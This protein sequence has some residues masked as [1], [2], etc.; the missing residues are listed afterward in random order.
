[1]V[2]IKLESEGYLIENKILFGA[3]VPHKDYINFAIEIG[4]D[5]V[6]E[7]LA[8]SIIEYPGEYDIDGIFIKSF[9]SKDGKLNYV[10]TINNKTIGLIQSPKILE[11]DDIR[12]LD[13][14][15]YLDDAVEKKLEQLELEGKKFKLDAEGGTL[16]IEEKESE[17]AEIVVEKEEE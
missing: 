15:L 16:K 10:F 7:K 8:Y 3:S 14:W 1:M 5:I 4:E 6:I 2:N 9:G 17:H 12:S 11:E 13:A